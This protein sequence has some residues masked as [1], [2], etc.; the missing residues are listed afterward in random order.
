MGMALARHVYFK[1]VLAYEQNL[2]SRQQIAENNIVQFSVK[3]KSPFLA[4]LAQGS[5]SAFAG[6]DLTVHSL[7]NWWPVHA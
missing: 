5:T 3:S 6:V 7:P 4:R 1:R 2:L